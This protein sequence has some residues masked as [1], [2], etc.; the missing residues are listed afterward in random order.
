VIDLLFVPASRAADGLRIGSAFPR[1]A[2]RHEEAGHHVAGGNRTH[3]LDPLGRVD[4]LAQGIKDFVRH[5]DVER[6]WLSSKQDLVERDQRVTAVLQKALTN[7][8]GWEFRGAVQPSPAA[9]IRFSGRQRLHLRIQIRL[10]LK[11]NTRE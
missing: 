5:F 3:Q 8:L 6:W 9:P 1:N 10:A 7:S 4:L 2:Q 11:P